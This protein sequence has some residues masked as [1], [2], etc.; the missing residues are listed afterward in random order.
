MPEKYYRSASRGGADKPVLH[1]VSS[2]PAL[3]GDIAE[4]SP[5]AIL[6]YSRSDGIVFINKK[7]RTLIDVESLDE[8]DD[9]LNYFSTGVIKDITRWCHHAIVTVFSE[10]S[11]ISEGRFVRGKKE[12]HLECKPV[13]VDS[14][15]PSLALIRIRERSSV[16]IELSRVADLLE[17]FRNPVF[18][19]DG[20]YRLLAANKAFL[21]RFRTH[22][23]STFCY[24]HLAG[25][26]HPCLGCPVAFV[27]ESEGRSLLKMPVMGRMAGVRF[28]YFGTLAGVPGVV[29]VSVME[30]DTDEEDSFEENTSE[31]TSEEKER[32]LSLGL[33]AR[34]TAHEWKNYV[35]ILSGYLQIIELRLTQ[36]GDS[37]LISR[38]DQVRNQFDQMSRS[39]LG[40]LE[41]SRD[42]PSKVPCLINDIIV[43]A[44]DFVSHHRKF[45]R[46]RI[47]VDSE[48]NLPFLMID[49]VQVEQVL[50]NL[51]KNAAE[52]MEWM[53]GVITIRSRHK[54]EEKCVEVTI[55]DTGGGIPPGRMSELFG[56]MESTKQEGYGIGLR[57][58][59]SVMEAHGGL[60]SVDS[61]RFG[62]VMRLRF[63]VP[64]E[65][66]ING[67]NEIF[68]RRELK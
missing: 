51:M 15:T 44:V 47:K 2:F 13:Y 17:I 11:G 18:L 46:I 31:N 53:D 64:S 63:P 42:K 66:E 43:S 36:I 29:L 38:I 12:Y 57:V 21:R 3:F 60:L 58:C 67:M 56:E 19:I 59:R 65:S 61:G 6:I 14:E 16:Q 49:V 33:M 25:I 10:K 20:D 52:A 40:L 32:I 41:I 24:L 9:T 62:A 55:E 45:E 22:E 7:G 48:K 5:E 37:S 4:H 50:V 34:D 1:A 54:V 35:A 8:Y 27:I 30:S 23:P 28:E 39:I 68:P 26:E